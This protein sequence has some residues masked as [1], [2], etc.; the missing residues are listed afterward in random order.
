MSRD[1]QEFPEQ[2]K[3]HLRQ[4]R[5]QKLRDRRRKDT[6]SSFQDHKNRKMKR[7]DNQDLD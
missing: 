6:F 2:G 5:E 3:E 1:F 7:W 4:K